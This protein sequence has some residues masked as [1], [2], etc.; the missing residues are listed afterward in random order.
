MKKVNT[1]LGV[2]LNLRILREKQKVGPD[3]YGYFRFSI[4]NLGYTV[5]FFLRLLVLQL[6]N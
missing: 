1:F 5:V 2:N 3:L 6:Q 4:L